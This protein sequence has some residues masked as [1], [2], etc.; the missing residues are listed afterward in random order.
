MSQ[1]KGFEVIAFLM[2]KCMEKF[3][4]VNLRVLR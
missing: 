2:N 3:K 1:P 4:C